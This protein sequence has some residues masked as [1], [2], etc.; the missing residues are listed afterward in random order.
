MHGRQRAGVFTG[1]WAAAET[2]SLALGPAIVGLI[3]AATGFVS[4]TGGETVTQ[5]T[6][7]LTG[8]V[9]AFSAFPALMMML[10]LPTLLKYDLT[11]SRLGD[12]R[13]AHAQ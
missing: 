1:V 9:L 13:G 12:L 4:S 10:S 7:A 3:L 11:E 8:I 5:P 2:V 6:S